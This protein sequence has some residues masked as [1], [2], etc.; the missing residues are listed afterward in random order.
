MSWSAEAAD[1]TAQAHE[2]P[3]PLRRLSGPARP[4]RYTA[5]ED[6]GVRRRAITRLAQ[7]HRLTNAYRWLGSG[8]TLVLVTG[9]LVI[10]VVAG[11]ATAVSKRAPETGAWTDVLTNPAVVGPGIVAALALLVRRALEMRLMGRAAAVQAVF[12][13]IQAGEEHHPERF[14]DFVRAVLEHVGKA[15]AHKCVIVEDLRRSDWL[16]QTIVL[17]Y[18]D[19]DSRPVVGEQVW[20]VFEHR[21][22][23]LVSAQLRRAGHAFHERHTEVRAQHYEQLLL[24]ERERIRLLELR[25]LPARAGYPRPVK[26]IVSGEQEPRPRDAAMFVAWRNDKGRSDGE[27]FDAVDFM[28]LLAVTETSS[29]GAWFDAET[30]KGTMAS[31]TSEGGRWEVQQA[32]VGRKLLSRDLTQVLQQLDSDEQLKLAMTR[33]PPGVY[34]IGY[35]AAL[36]LRSARGQIDLADTALCHLFW[37]LYWHDRKR[38]D[39]GAIW[40]RKLAHH[41]REAGVPAR[42]GLAAELGNPLLEAAVHAVRG[43]VKG[44]ALAFNRSGDRRRVN[45]LPELLA[46]AI[47]LAEAATEKR[48]VA[49]LRRAAWDAYSLLGDEGILRNLLKLEATAGAL[50]G[51]PDPL[52]RLFV[53]T[54]AVEHTRPHVLAVLPGLDRSAADF[55]SVRAAWLALTLTSASSDAPPRAHAALETVGRQLPSAVQHAVLRVEAELNAAGA[56]AAVDVAIASLGCWCLA[57]AARAGQVES[58]AAIDALSDVYLL[59]KLLPRTDRRGAYM[60]EDDADFVREGLEQELL[61]VAGAS[62]ALLDPDSLSDNRRADLDDLMREAAGCGSPA[63]RAHVI[64]EIT[65]RM[66]LTEFMWERLGFAQLRSFMSLRRAQFVVA[67]GEELSS[68]AYGAALDLLFRE[69]EQPGVQ[70]LLARAIVAPAAGHKTH[71]AGDLCRGIELALKA[72]VSAELAQEL[73]VM[74]LHVANAHSDV[75]REEMLKRLL[76]VDEHSGDGPII[77]R[78]FATLTDYELATAF[79]VLGNAVDRTSA[80]PFVEPAYAAMHRR[81]DAASSEGTDRARRALHLFQLDRDLRSGVDLALDDTRLYWRSVLQID[82]NQA[83]W[84]VQLMLHHGWSDEKTVRFG[85]EV[86]EYQAT[87]APNWNAFFLAKSLANKLNWAPLAGLGDAEREAALAAAIAYVESGYD[88]HAAKLAPHEYRAALELLIEHKPERGPEYRDALEKFDRR[89]QRELLTRFL[90]P[91]KQRGEHFAVVW[92][93]VTNLAAWGLTAHPHKPSGAIVAMTQQEREAEV[94]RCLR[95]DWPQPFIDSPHGKAVA[96]EFLVAAYSLLETDLPGLRGLTEARALV[97]D[98]ARAMLDPL[99][100]LAIELPK[101]P[102][103]YRAVLERHREALNIPSAAAA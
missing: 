1:E 53:D 69:S 90:L 16:T 98:R 56:S 100:E 59:A 47:E 83:A 101:L 29:G 12:A 65:R 19:G 89:Y 7:T 74:A 49:D 82:A 5:L 81:L 58:S 27:G 8:R 38:H 30:I 61:V 10:G 71:S 67:L 14:K 13:D 48:P 50:Q 18:L 26:F 57:I 21:D 66:G 25:G 86:L 34:E 17:A 20:I 68:D 31:H 40:V 77:D 33:Q 84:A 97:E 42:F 36:A 28:H 88:V 93:Y 102:G 6:L 95:S 73:C 85:I 39:A 79:T 94:R 91:A 103:A 4:G 24:D 52:H 35:A 55:A 3:Y 60:R 54:L 44:V 45:E 63:T 96:A 76:E 11:I 64:E 9:L 75:P 51:R 62:A 2:Y 46:A 99:L 43:Y 23:P 37:A 70:G 87:R 22:D 80:A 72:G 92:H 32:I 41:V 78:W 15:C